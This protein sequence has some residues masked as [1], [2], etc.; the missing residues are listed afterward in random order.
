M[1]YWRVHKLAELVTRKVF[2]RQKR[3]PCLM[4]S[5]YMCVT[6]LDGQLK[7]TECYSVNA[8]DKTFIFVVDDE[9]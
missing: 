9:E 7:H 5:I 8:K 6:E 3:S 2:S 1:K 4:L